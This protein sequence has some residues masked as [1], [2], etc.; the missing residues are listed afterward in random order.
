M[1]CN[2]DDGVTTVRSHTCKGTLINARYREQLIMGQFF[3]FLFL[4]FVAYCFN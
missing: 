1:K 2:W 3:L 4:F